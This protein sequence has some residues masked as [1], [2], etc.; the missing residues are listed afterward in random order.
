MSNNRWR[1]CLL[2]TKI[3]GSMRHIEKEEFYRYAVNDQC[4]QNVYKTAIAT[5]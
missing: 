4:I 1:I 5:R 3:E 2:S